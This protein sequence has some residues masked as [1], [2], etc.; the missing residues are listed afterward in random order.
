MITIYGTP[1][2]AKC[3]Q[4]KLVLEAAQIQYEYKSIGAD[5]QREEFF[6][7]FATLGLTAPRTVP[8]IFNDAEYIGGFDELKRWLQQ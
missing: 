2:C 1:T 3:K 8:Q 6:D 7:M 4:T 5:I